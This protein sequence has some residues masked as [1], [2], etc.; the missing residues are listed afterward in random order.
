VPDTLFRQGWR[1][2]WRI[3][4]KHL[5]AT[6]QQPTG[7]RQASTAE[8]FHGAGMRRNSGHHF[9][10]F[11]IGEIKRLEDFKVRKLD[12]LG[13]QPLA[14]HG[15]Q[16]F[17]EPGT[18]KNNLLADLV[19]RKRRKKNGVYMSVPIERVVCMAGAAEGMSLRLDDANRLRSRRV[20][21]LLLLPRI[22]R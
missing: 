9:A 20:S 13:M 16:N 17:K 8:H 15:Q 12:L 22:G 10:G 18:G 21:E 14:R 2:G 11:R 1:D 4:V 6:M 19:I 5:G 7:L 3:A